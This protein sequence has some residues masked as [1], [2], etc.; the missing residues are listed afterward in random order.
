MHRLWNMREKLPDGC[1]TTGSEDQKSSYQ[2]CGGLPD[3]SPVQ[4]VLPGGRNHHNTGKIHSGN[5]LMG[6]MMKEQIQKTGIV[7][8]V[9]LFIGLPLFLYTTGNFPERTALKEG[10]S[11]LTILAFCLMIGQF[12]LTR[13]NRR[14]LN[15][16]LHS[17]IVK[18]HKF[19][20]YIFLPVLFVHP[21]LIVV[22]RYYESGV[23]PMEAF[24]TIITT[25]NSV[26]IVL[27]ICAWFLMLILGAASLFR[28]KLPLKY[29]TWRF[30]HGIL[31]ILFIIIAS[32]HAIDLGRH[33]D[34]L[35][36]AYV[37]IAALS[38][39]LLLLKT[40]VSESLIKQ[41]SGK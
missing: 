22:P 26:G 7:S 4:D 39:V 3:M 29:T 10:I 38:G 35:L 14:M 17:S 34:S 24:L 40:Y 13:M 36:T 15:G 32:W 25:V 20:G 6:L 21:F 8:L 19:L 1:N 12:F 37:I 11:V 9:V 16:Y 31:A 41:E 27:G 23:D 28:K 18:M 5:S 30:I 33:T 2:I